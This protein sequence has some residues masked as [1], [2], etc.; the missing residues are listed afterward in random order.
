M[1]LTSGPSFNL[2]Y[3]K[4]IV[5]INFCY[6]D[7]RLKLIIVMFAYPVYIFKCSYTSFIRLNF[8]FGLPTKNLSF[9]LYVKKPSIS[10]DAVWNDDSSL[11]IQSCLG[12]IW[13]CSVQI[14]AGAPAV[15]TDCI[16]GKCGYGV[17]FLCHFQFIAH[18]I[19]IIS[20][21]T[22]LCSCDIEYQPLP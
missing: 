1:L 14:S 5:S 10:Y 18:T 11:M 9:P 15:L 8:C 6:I 22:N 7:L 16:L 20:L 17:C 19:L 2:L 4:I 21:N 12:G 3:M 13:F